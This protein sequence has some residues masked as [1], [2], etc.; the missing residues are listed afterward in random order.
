MPK[1]GLNQTAGVKLKIFSAHKNKE[2]DLAISLCTAG[3]RTLHT[4]RTEELKD[5]KV[6][7]EEHSED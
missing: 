2:R 4:T 3:T 5:N 1:A 7:S 6:N